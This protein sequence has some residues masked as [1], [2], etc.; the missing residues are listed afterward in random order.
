MRSRI[1]R[2]V[3]RE[4]NVKSV[5]LADFARPSSTWRRSTR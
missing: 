4:D 3:S 1:G 5:A 2:M